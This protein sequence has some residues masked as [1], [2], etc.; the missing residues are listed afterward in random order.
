MLLEGEGLFNDASSLTLFEVF[1]KLVAAPQKEG[2]ADAHG[3]R[4]AASA[5][6]QLSEIGQDL[7]WFTVGGAIV[8]IATAI[9]T[10]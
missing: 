10:Q 2:G 5:M 9:T 6:E 8:G 1:S 3:V 7:A 4:A